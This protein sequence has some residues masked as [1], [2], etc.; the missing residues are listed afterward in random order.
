MRH[1]VWFSGAS[2]RKEMFDVLTKLKIGALIIDSAIRRDC[3]HMEL[4]IPKSFIRYVGNSLHATDYLRINDWVD[5]M[6]Y[7]L[8]NGM[9]EL[10]F[11]M[12]MHNETLSA[13]LTVYLIDKLNDVCGLNL[14]RPG[15]NN[16][17]SSLFD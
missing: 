16:N 1:P 12:H 11:F 3:A 9:E 7:W 4:T 17:S 15:L 8:D 5:R 10:Y 2:V 13:E 14:I 6:K